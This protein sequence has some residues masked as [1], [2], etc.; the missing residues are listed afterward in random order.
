MHWGTGALVGALRG[1]WS[2]TGIRGGEATLTHAVVRLAFD[3][4]VEN[5][6]GVG[7]PP[8]TWPRSERLVDVGHKAVYAFVTGAVSDR[9]VP[10]AL[11]STR[12]LTSH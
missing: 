9:I 12:G 7:A 10:P 3:Q 2:A 11:R 5:T 8:A 1:V 4:T 6:T